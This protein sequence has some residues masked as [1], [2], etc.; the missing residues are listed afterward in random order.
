MVL[1]VFCRDNIWHQVG[2]PAK[3]NPNIREAACFRMTA[4]PWPTL[5]LPVSG[6]WCCWPWA[7]L[8]GVCFPDRGSVVRLWWVDLALPFPIRFLSLFISL[9]LVN[10]TLDPA[11]FP[12]LQLQFD[13]HYPECHP[14]C[15]TPPKGK[16]RRCPHSAPGHTKVHVFTLKI[17][18]S[19]W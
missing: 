2:Q 15:S 19:T 11:W 12:C 8:A 3:Q 10:L 7:E 18:N 4:Q 5:V 9:E 6:L 1:D 13:S 16:S 17:L 14:D